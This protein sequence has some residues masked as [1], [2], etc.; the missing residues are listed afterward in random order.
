MAQ[1]IPLGDGAVVDQHFTEP[2]KRV[3]DSWQGR[4]VGFEVFVLAGQDISPFPRL[5]VHNER[6][7]FEQVRLHFQCDRHLPVGDFET[8]ITELGVNRNGKRNDDPQNEGDDDLERQGRFDHCRR[9]IGV[10]HQ[11]YNQ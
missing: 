2:V 1:D 11:L 8:A 10:R 9:R 3:V 6:Y 7:R 5:G 4:A